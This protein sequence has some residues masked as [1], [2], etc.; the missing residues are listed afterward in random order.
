MGQTVY[1]DLLFL[2][3]FSMDVLALYLTAR[4][5]SRRPKLWR[6]LLAGCVGGLY[7]CLAL[8]SPLNGFSALSVDLL[9]C[10]LLGW[11]TFFSRKGQRSVLPPLLTFP[12][13]SM[14]LGGVMTALF[15]LLNRLHLPL[16]T[17]TGDGDGI[18]VWLFA[19]LAAVSALLTLF[20]GRFF[21]KRGSIKE[22]ELTIVVGDRS[23]CLTALTD[24]CNLL[25]EPISGKPCVVAEIGCF[26]GLLPDSV[27]H[28]A[29]RKQLP[30]L[31]TMK[32]LSGAGFRLIPAQ[33]A[34]G[35]GLLLGF[36]PTRMT[37]HTK[38]GEREADAYLVLTHLSAS[39]MGCRALLPLTL[40]T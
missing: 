23:I 37:V 29:E 8:F 2:I 9:V 39:A 12:A 19:L 30:P 38:Q 28:A 25:C 17:Q 24:S 18:S 15:T 40:L 6:L 20:G 3:N 35:E 31:E 13:V 21:A 1:V 7:S 32:G 26:R 33:T 27:L 11:I 16:D 34:S 36:R 5:L 10:L 14:A 4:I 22:A